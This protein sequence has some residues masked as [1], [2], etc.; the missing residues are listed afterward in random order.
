M[1]EP[2]AT[3]LVV[4]FTLL[5][6]IVFALGWLLAGISRDVTTLSKLCREECEQRIRQDKVRTDGEESNA[7]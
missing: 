2:L 7:T 6:V 3:I 4:A 1:S 5:C